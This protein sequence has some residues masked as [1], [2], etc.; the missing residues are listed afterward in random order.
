[1]EYKWVL[2]G[3][4]SFWKAEYGKKWAKLTILWDTIKKW[5]ISRVYA[6]LEVESFILKV[7]IDWSIHD[8]I[9]R[10]LQEK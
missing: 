3:K 9:C 4:L 7:R 2:R 10:Y 8:L 5:K 6:Q 1:M